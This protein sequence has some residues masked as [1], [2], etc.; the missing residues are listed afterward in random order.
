MSEEYK[1]ATLKNPTK[2]SYEIKITA[3]ELTFLGVRSQPDFAILE[4]IMIPDEK[5]IELKSL[6]YYLL[7]FRD[8]VY[9]YEHLINLVFDDLWA[10]YKPRKLKVVMTTNPRGG[11]SSI[12]TVDSDVRYKK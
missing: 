12:L 10:I 3:P 6:K 4:I 2:E 9:S 7:N 1:L 8:K 5:I 11:I